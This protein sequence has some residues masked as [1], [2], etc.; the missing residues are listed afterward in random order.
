MAVPVVGAGLIIAGGA[1]LPPGR[2]RSRSS[3]CHPSSG[4]G[5]RSYSLYLWHWPILI[6]AA[7]QAG[8][9]QPAGRARTWCWWWSPSAWPW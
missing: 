1:W 3:D 2:G 8:K 7:E 5:E 9:L 6:I 4:S